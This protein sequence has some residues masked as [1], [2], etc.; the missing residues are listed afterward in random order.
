MEA[1]GKAFVKVII[2]TAFKHEE[3]E[4]SCVEIS[5]EAGADF[6]KTSTGF[7]QVEPKKRDVQLM[8]KTVGEKHRCKG[9][10]WE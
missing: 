3:K 6:V 9:I 1:K 2:E 5:K 4:E 8:R 7:L 10:R